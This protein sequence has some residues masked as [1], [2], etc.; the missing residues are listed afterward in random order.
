M[1]LRE[2]LAAIIRRALEEN[3]LVIVNFHMVHPSLMKYFFLHV[4]ESCKINHPGVNNSGFSLLQTKDSYRI[5]NGL[6]YNLC[7]IHHLH[8]LV[9]FTLKL[10][11]INSPNGNNTIKI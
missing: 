7:K 5:V 8:I 11:K 3:L 10:L 4:Y 6:W 9:E 2:I 1:N